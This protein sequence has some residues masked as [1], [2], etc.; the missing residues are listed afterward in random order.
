MQ[1]PFFF[2]RLSESFGA[3][4]SGVLS[5]AAPSFVGFFVFG[6][7][8]ARYCP[9]VSFFVRGLWLILSLRLL[10]FRSCPPRLAVCRMS[11]S[12]GS[13]PL[14]VFFI[15]PT[16]LL[17]CVPRQL[18]FFPPEASLIRE[19]RFLIFQV[20]FEIVLFRQGV[21]FAFSSASLLA[22][23]FSLCAP[24]SQRSSSSTDDI[25][26]FLRRLTRINSPEGFL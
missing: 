17:S 8:A 11:A 21:S 26:Q 15:T 3:A 7:D 20:C 13:I 19:L 10:F 14:F 5:F 24:A 12:E 25:F 18:C 16:S 23:S 4:A 1:Q 22:S 9:P 2:G 6:G